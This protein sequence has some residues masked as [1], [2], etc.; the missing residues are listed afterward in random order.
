VIRPVLWRFDVG[1]EEERMKDRVNASIFPR[2]RDIES[3]GD[4]SE[5]GGDDK[6]AKLFSIKLCFRSLRA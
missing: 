2:R 1:C 3:V 6:G 5:F 4:G